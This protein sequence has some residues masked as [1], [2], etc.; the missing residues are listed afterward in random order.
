MDDKSTNVQIA[1]CVVIR[2]KYCVREVIARGHVIYSG[3]KGYIIPNTKNVPEEIIVDGSDARLATRAGERLRQGLLEVI[4]RLGPILVALQVLEF[5]LW[6]RL[7]RRR[8]LRRRRHRL[9]LFM[10]IYYQNLTS[11][12]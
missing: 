9:F 5:R 7:W 4:E 3:N 11:N 6:R 10:L 1:E 2:S 12:Y 8:L